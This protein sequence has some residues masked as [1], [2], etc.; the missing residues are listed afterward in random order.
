LNCPEFGWRRLGE[1]A[2]VLL[3]AEQSTREN[4]ILFLA[5]HQRGDSCCSLFDETQITANILIWCGFVLIQSDKMSS[6]TIF[7]R[8]FAGNKRLEDDQKSLSSVSGT[9]RIVF[10]REIMFLFQKRPF[11]LKVNFG[12]IKTNLA[13]LISEELTPEDMTT[14]WTDQPSRMTRRRTSF[15]IDS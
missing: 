3:L 15:R 9:I 10:L 13:A 8:L 4:R 2:K 1:K 7:F 12:T 14:S 11:M 6:R 5:G